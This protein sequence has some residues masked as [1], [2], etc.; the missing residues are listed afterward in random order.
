MIKGA[1]PIS[2]THKF[3]VLVL[4]WCHHPLTRGDGQEC[5][6]Y[7]WS[8]V[9][10]S[11]PTLRVRIS[12]FAALILKITFQSVSYNK[13]MAYSLR[14]ELQISDEDDQMLPCFM[15]PECSQ[16]LWL[17]WYCSCVAWIIRMN[18]FFWAFSSLRWRKCCQLHVQKSEFK[19]RHYICIWM[20][21]MEMLQALYIFGLFILN[22]WY[23][24]LS[25]YI[26]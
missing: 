4:M 20:S 14:G 13:L 18:E 22:W 9:L 15:A 17:L 5:S 2:H 21:W 3:S 16:N 24:L 10:T 11:G 12:D 19:L 25:L 6:R 23:I 7:I 1:S 8:S 26:L